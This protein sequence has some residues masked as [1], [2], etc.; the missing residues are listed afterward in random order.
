LP[1]LYLH[2]ALGSDP[3]RRPRAAILWHLVPMLAVTASVLADAF[4][5][6]DPVLFITYGVYLWALTGLHRLGARH[7]SGLGPYLGT[8]MVWLRI[9]IAVICASLVLEV[10][11]FTELV[12]GG[13]FRASLP[14]LL[15]TTLFFGLVSYALLGAMG[16]PSLFEHV[17]NMLAERA[18]PQN[19]EDGRPRPGSADHDLFARLDVFFDDPE[20]LAD[21]TLTLTRVS[22]RLGVPA[23]SV[24]VAVNRVAE[25]SFSDLL[26]DRR[27]SLATRLIDEDP[28]RP[29]LDIIYAAGF[30]AKSNFYI[31][32]KRRTGVTPAAYRAQ[33]VAGHRSRHR[34]ACL[35]QTGTAPNDHK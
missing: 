3:D 7:F 21:D 15:S 31:Q 28:D 30:G 27:I 19:G 11:I 9:V 10:A 1:A 8:T 22:R 12:R 33:G 20:I 4:W 6:I 24:S 17:Y 23:R 26:N 25:Q 16:R 32:F 5:A 13:A 2:F 35:G 34:A 29:L 14:L 18:P